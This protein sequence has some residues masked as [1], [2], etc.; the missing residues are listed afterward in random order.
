MVSRTAC[1]R[2]CCRQCDKVLARQPDNVKALY[3]RAQAQARPSQPT[4]PPP[5]LL[6]LSPGSPGQPQGAPPAAAYGEQ[7]E[8]TAAL[9]D[10]EAC[11]A[12]DGGNADAAKLRARLQTAQRQRTAREQAQY[13]GLFAP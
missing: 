3:R 7:Q 2:Q 9:R 8:Y 10:A 12:L 1:R 13:R 6:R 11:L 4:P 5:K